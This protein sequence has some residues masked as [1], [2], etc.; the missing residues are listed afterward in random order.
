M[1]IESIT[2][3]ELFKNEQ[4][5]S[6]PI[7]MDIQHDRFIW[8]DGNPYN[9][10]NGH[11]RVINDTR[12]VKFNGKTY[13]P[14]SF[15]FEAPSEDGKTTGSASVTISAVDR[16]IIEIIEKID[17]PPECEIEAYFEKIDENRVKFTRLFGYKLKMGSVVF[18]KLTARWNLVFSS[19]LQLNIPRD[20]GTEIRCPAAKE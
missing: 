15:S 3:E 7:L 16:R 1:R 13:V 14:M 9:Q 5:G 20:V 17:T 19:L 11:F 6:V 18:D 4:P 12:G 10:E 2:L 8:Q